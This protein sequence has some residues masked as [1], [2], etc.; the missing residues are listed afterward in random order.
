MKK[1]MKMPGFT[2]E[3]SLYKQSKHYNLGVN[4]G[5]HAEGQVVIPQ[6]DWC[7]DHY[8]PEYY[9]GS[10]Y[11]CYAACIKDSRCTDRKCRY[12]SV[13]DYHGEYPLPPPPLPELR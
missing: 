3:A 4:P 10:H 12:E 6:Y 13:C 11:K 9:G 1:E 7:K 8:Q 2:A 5:A